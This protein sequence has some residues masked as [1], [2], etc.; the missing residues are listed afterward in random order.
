MVKEIQDIVGKNTDFMKV[1]EI[2]KSIEGRI[3]SP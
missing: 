3:S 1:I 2:G